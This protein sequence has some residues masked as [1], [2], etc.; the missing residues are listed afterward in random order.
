LRRPYHVLWVALLYLPPSPSLRTSLSAAGYSLRAQF[1][2][3]DA[4]VL[5]LGRGRHALTV[6]VGADGRCGPVTLP[7]NLP[8]KVGTALKAHVETTVQQVHE[9]VAR[10]VHLGRARLSERR[11]DP[12]WSRIERWARGEE[13]EDGPVPAWRPDVPVQ[14]AVEALIRSVAAGDLDGQATWRLELASRSALDARVLAAMHVLVGDGEAARSVGPLPASGDTRSLWAWLQGTAPAGASAVDLEEVPLPVRIQVAARAAW[15]W[16]TDDPSAPKTYGHPGCPP[17]PTPHVPPAPAALVEAFERD[18]FV[19][20]RGALSPAVVGAWTRRVL[21]HYQ[22]HRHTLDDAESPFRD[23]VDPSSPHFSRR[24][25]LRWRTEDQAP[26]HLMSP[27][28]AGMTDALFGMARL[29]CRMPDALLCTRTAPPS[30]FV[31]HELNWHLDETPEQ[32]HID[33]QSLAFLALV[34]LTDVER[35]DG[36]TTFLP[37]SPAVVARS[38]V[39]SPGLPQDDRQWTASLAAQCTRQE[40]CTGKAGDIYLL[41]PLTLHTRDRPHRY[42]SR[43]ISNLNLFARAPLSYRSPTNA[44]ERFVRLGGPSGD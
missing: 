3:N 22:H 32:R 33:R 26:L 9:E 42:A 6:T 23:P 39:A 12:S 8:P 21:A 25:T 17:E 44:V 10:L 19:V 28:L 16:G 37:E 38:L 41:H 24:G 34:L 4:L 2:R 18:G 29:H 14:E 27:L 5:H 13:L 31:E 43:I 36:P 7:K 11:S 15:W 30:R 20:L 40:W 1:F 35:E